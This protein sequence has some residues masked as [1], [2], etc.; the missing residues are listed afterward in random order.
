MILALDTNSSFESFIVVFIQSNGILKLASKKNIIN[1]S[2]IIRFINFKDLLEKIKELLE[3]KTS[4]NIKLSKDN[5][6]FTQNHGY[7]GRY[8]ILIYFDINVLKTLGGFGTI[9]HG[10]FQL[11]SIVKY[12]KKFELLS[13]DTYRENTNYITLIEIINNQTIKNLLID[14]FK[15]KKNNYEIIKQ[16]ILNYK[17]ML[18][19]ITKD[20]LSHQ[21]NLIYAFENIEI[22]D[23]NM[24][25]E[26]EYSYYIKKFLSDFINHLGGLVSL[27]NTYHIK[28]ICLVP[29]KR[30]IT[31]IAANS[32]Y[33]FS[34]FLSNLYVLFLQDYTLLILGKKISKILEID[35][36]R[37]YNAKDMSYIMYNKHINMIKKE[38]LTIKP[39][40]NNQV[41]LMEYKVCPQEYSK[42][43][44]VHLLLYYG[45]C[46][47]RIYGVFKGQI[48]TY[49]YKTFFI[50]IASGTEKEI[51]HLTLSNGIQTHYYSSHFITAF[52]IS[53]DNS[54]KRAIKK[55]IAKF[56]KDFTKRLPFY[57]E[58]IYKLND[59][60]IEIDFQ[61]LYFELLSTDKEHLILNTAIV[62]NIFSDV[63]I[64]KYNK[65]KRHNAVLYD[66]YET[67]NNKGKLKIKITNQPEIEQIIDNTISNGTNIIFY[68]Y[69][70]I[71]GTKIKQFVKKGKYKVKKGFILLP[72]D[73]SMTKEV[74]YIMIDSDL[75]VEELLKDAP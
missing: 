54:L 13:I 21:D 45:N 16:Y 52:F 18:K 22:Q 24:Y 69:L 72:I 51:S 5:I 15:N 61:N 12:N 14:Q 30:I 26:D 27:G 53:K 29:H 3:E 43:G 44:Y 50:L 63:L 75:D 68:F 4:S 73:H 20:Y 7:I 66:F 65:T 9:M 64:N 62:T 59:L 1:K 71:E 34:L 46:D 57:T 70:K 47:L 41:S 74:I 37:L 25:E 36:H 49:H 6:F 56:F 38:I 58:F 40:P 8:K 67:F 23:N 33:Y 11:T 48:D 55:M 2:K 42:Y 60:Y 39:K 31:Q 32:D 17:Y 10:D 35:K 19:N 28:K